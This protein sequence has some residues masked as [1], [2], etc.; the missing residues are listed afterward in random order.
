MNPNHGH[1]GA[2]SQIGKMVPRQVSVTSPDHQPENKKLGGSK[3][4][5][6]NPVGREVNPQ[7][8]RSGGNPIL[9]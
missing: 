7:M 5:E 4:M 6:G 1:K 2:D 8:K 3:Y 9:T